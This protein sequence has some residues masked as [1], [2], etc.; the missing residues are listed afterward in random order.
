MSRKTVFEIEKTC[1]ECGETKH[2]KFFELPGKALSCFHPCGTRKA[3]GRCL[4]CNKKLKAIYNSTPERL[5]KF[6]ERNYK[7]NPLKTYPKIVN[8]KVRRF[9]LDTHKPV[10]STRKTPL[11]FCHLYKTCSECGIEKYHKEFYKTK[12]NEDGTMCTNRKCKDCYTKHAKSLWESKTEEQKKEIRRKNN[13]RQRNWR[14]DNKEHVIER[15]K[16]YQEE[17]WTKLTDAFVKKNL[18][19]NKFGIK[20]GTEIPQE[21]IE[22]TREVLKLNRL[23]RKLK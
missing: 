8:G 15:Q 11:D 10:Y 16:K 7:R 18:R 5:A 6:R 20:A 1:G 3:T 13:I 12:L 23:I 22:L 14:K 9:Y 17:S 21:L 2:R 19:S 4:D